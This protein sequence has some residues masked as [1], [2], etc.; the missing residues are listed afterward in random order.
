MSN[1]LNWIEKKSKKSHSNRFLIIKKVR[2][3]FVIVRAYIFMSISDNLMEKCRILQAKLENK[4]KSL[5]WKNI[6]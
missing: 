6:G 2:A 3:L 5:A 1:K 4:V